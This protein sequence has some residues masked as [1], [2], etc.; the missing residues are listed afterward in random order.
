MQMDKMKENLIA[1]KFSTALSLLK[2]PSKMILP[3]G[4]NGLL[5]FI[6]DK[7]YLKL[8]FKA[9]MGYPLNLEHPK[10]YN[11]KMQWLKIYDR[12][13]EY[14]LY[15]DKYLVRDYIANKIGSKYL[16]PL[17]GVYKSSSEIPWD[18]LPAQF[19]L[20]CNHASGTNII[21]TDK[22]KL[23]YSAVSE[24]L[25]R[26]LRYN[27]Y[28]RG[29]EWCYKDIEPCIIC[30]EFIGTDEGQTPDDF[31]FMCFNG[32]PRLIQ[33]HHD[34]Y[35]DHTLDFMDIHW[36]KTG[37]VQGPKNSDKEISK[38]DT[39]EEML[40]I[41]K[42]LAKDMYYARVDLYS[43]NHNVKFGEITMYPTSGFSPFEKMETDN[44]LGSWIRLPVKEQ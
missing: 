23:D 11:E 2:S 5:K 25:D 21:C 18:S 39:F 20:K 42:T 29:R 36:N 22:S 17:I 37:I 8:A 28:W 41:A 16:V 31:K 30:E 4:Q 38:P 10:T 35:G 26:W 44:L 7:L 3:M 1:R 13:P 12:K 14:I 32:E 34:R 24:Q 40:G 15:A 9:E 27:A 43:M 6:P 33:V 19:V